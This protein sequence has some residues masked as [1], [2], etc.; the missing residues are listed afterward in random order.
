VA[1]AT[2]FDGDNSVPLAHNYFVPT[3]DEYSFQVR[4][5]RRRAMLCENYSPLGNNFHFDPSGADVRR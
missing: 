2:I 1:Y 5:L 3:G 4:I